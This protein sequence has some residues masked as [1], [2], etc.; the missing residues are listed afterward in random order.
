MYKL[1]VYIYSV[2]TCIIYFSKRWKSL[3]MSTALFRISHIDWQIP[4]D[5]L[6]FPKLRWP[7]FLYAEFLPKSLF[8]LP[9]WFPCWD[10]SRGRT[11][12]WFRA[13]VLVLPCKRRGGGRICWLKQVC[14]CPCVGEHTCTS[15]GKMR[16]K[17]P[18]LCLKKGEQL[19][20]LGS[21]LI[22]CAALT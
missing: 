3:L 4:C 15:N 9:V 11:E 5:D 20:P 6:L 22:D 18:S 1:N 13:I 8:P 12:V 7:R 19:C 14:V 16:R 21:N 17:P 2:L 10:S